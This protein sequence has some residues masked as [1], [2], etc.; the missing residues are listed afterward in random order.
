[1]CI[2]TFAVAQLIPNLSILLS[3]IGAVFCSILVFIFPAL[4][5]LTTR[6]AQYGKVGFGYWMKNLIIILLALI[7]MILGGGQAVYE[8]YL[9][10]F[11]DSK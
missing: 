7:G 5:E 6:K 3:L 10:F 4:I 2:V 1:M 9:G 8:I 11:N